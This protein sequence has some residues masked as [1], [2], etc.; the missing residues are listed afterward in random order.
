MSTVRRDER[1]SEEIAV[2]SLAFAE[3]VKN[4]LGVKAMHHEVLKG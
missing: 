3:R 2:G 4:D 1:W